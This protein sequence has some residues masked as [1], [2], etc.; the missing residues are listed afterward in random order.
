MHLKKLTL[1]IVLATALPAVAVD[2][3]DTDTST[4]GGTIPELAQLVV[5]GA[6]AAALLTLAQDGAGETAYDAGG[7]ASAADAI[8]LTVDANKQWQLGALVGVWT[9]PVGYNKAEADMEIQITNSPTGT[10]QGGAATYVGLSTSN[11]VI[12]DH[13]AGVSDN[14]VD[15]QANVVLDW[16]QDIPGVYSIVI[17]W[18]METTP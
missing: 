13:T 11:L 6:G 4:I 15:I 12:L 14:Q 10:I 2:D 3:V 9:D 18:Q 16:T 1:A 7:I 8:Q 17:T 5:G